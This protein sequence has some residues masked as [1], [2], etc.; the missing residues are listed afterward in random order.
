MLVKQLR[1]KPENKDLTITSSSFIPVVGGALNVTGLPSSIAQG[2]TSSKAVKVTELTCW[3]DLGKI[4]VCH[5]GVGDI[6]SLVQ[7]LISAILVIFEQ[8]YNAG[9]QVFLNP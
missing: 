9:T 6:E 7:D 8:P 4:W 2:Q 5:V 1:I 3:Q